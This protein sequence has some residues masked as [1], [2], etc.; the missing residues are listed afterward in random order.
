[1]EDVK[2]IHLI[3]DETRF[4][5]LQLLLSHPYCVRA[6]SRKLGISEPAVSQ[7]MKL[8]RQ[9]Q[10]VE[11]IKI[12]YQVHYRVD[13]KKLSDA[14]DSFVRQIRQ[15]SALPELSSASDCRCELESECRKRDAKFLED[16]KHD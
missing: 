15:Y 16:K 9:Y 6:L 14:L 1:M 2:L 13:R 4:R 7:Q 8:F 3:S 5:L 11:G 12:G 10:L